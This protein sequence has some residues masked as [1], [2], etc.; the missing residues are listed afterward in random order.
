MR[1]NL[2]H[3][4]FERDSDC[5]KNN[6][7][8]DY[9]IIDKNMGIEY[10]NT[11]EEY[12]ILDVNLL[13]GEKM[14]IIYDD[15]HYYLKNG[16]KDNINI[17]SSLKKEYIINLNPEP[18]V[19]YYRIIKN[20][21]S[22]INEIRFGKSNYLKY[23]GQSEK[24]N[25]NF[26]FYI[27]L[28]NINFTSNDLHLNYKFLKIEN[29]YFPDNENVEIF[30]VDESFIIKEKEGLNNNKG[31][32][33]LTNLNE[34]SY[35]QKDMGAGY[36]LLNKNSILENLENN[37][38][39]LY[40]KFSNKPS[41]EFDFVIT[42]TDFSENYDMPQDIY[43][44]MFIKDTTHLKVYATEKGSK[45]PFLEISHDR[46]LTV[47][48]D[49]S[50]IQET[51]A[52]GKIFLSLLK[53]EINVITFKNIGKEELMPNLLFKYSFSL[54][55]HNFSYFELI[56]NSIKFNDED[57][58]KKMVSFYQIKSISDYTEYSVI[59][60]I[61][62]FDKDYDFDGILEKKKPLGHLIYK[63]QQFSEEMIE[64]NIMEELGLNFGKLY[65]NI[66]AEAKIKNKEEE[67]YEYILYKYKDIFIKAE[68]IK[69][70]ITIREKEN[71]SYF[72]YAE[73]I[74]INAT[75]DLEVGD[76]T[77]YKYIKLIL[78][79]IGEKQQLDKFE[80]YA[81]TK[82]SFLNVV[83][84]DLYK[85][86]EY[87]SIDSYNNSVLAIP[88]KNLV[89]NES[90]SQLYIQIPCKTTREF[91]FI[92]RIED[93]RKME[94][95][96]IHENTCFDI[97]LE[98][99]DEGTSNLNYRF[100]YT[101]KEKKCPLITFTTY[102]INNNYKVFT[103]G[104]EN[105]FLKKSFYN[106]YSFLFR[107]SDD[108]YEYHTF[109]IVPKI[110]TTVKICHRMIE[111]E[112]E[113]MGGEIE[114]IFRKISVGEN[115][116][117]FL[118]NNKGIIKDCF[119]LEKKDN[120]NQYMFNYISKTQN[121]RLII[122]KNKKEQENIINLYN[123]TETK[124][125]NNLSYFCIGL[126]ENDEESIETE[127]EFHG[128]INFQILG[129]DNEQ[130]INPPLVQ[131]IN[132][133][134]VKHTLQPRQMLYYR[135]NKY[136]YESE[137]LELYF[138]DL[139]GDILIKQYNYENYPNYTVKPDMPEGA[140]DIGEAFYK[141]N[142]YHKIN[143]VDKED[144]YN[145][146]KFPVYIVKCNNSSYDNCV[147]FI[148]MNNENSILEL[149]AKRKL[150]I[151]TKEEKTF[152][153]STDFYS[154]I[155]L[156]PKIDPGPWEKGSQ[157]YYFEIHLLKGKLDT[158]NISLNNSY[159]L[160]YNIDKKT[161]YYTSFAKNSF[162]VDFY[163]FPIELPI[164]NDTFFYITYRILLNENYEG[165]KIDDIY[166]MYENEMHYNLLTPLLETF[167]YY[168]PEVQFE[169]DIPKEQYIVSISGINS[170]LTLE[171]QKEIKYHQF[172]L[173][174]KVTKIT[175]K[176]END[177]KTA[178]R[179]C[180]FIFS[181][182][183]LNINT[184]SIYKKVEFDGFYQYYEMN[185]NI[186]NVCL[187]YDLTEEEIKR[188]YILVTIIKDNLE[189][190]TIYYGYETYNAPEDFE[191]LLN[192]TSIIEKNF[193]YRIN[194]TE[195]MEKNKKK[196]DQDTKKF[197]MFRLNSEKS[198]SFR[199][200]INIKN[201]PVHLY[202]DEIE[203]GNLKPNEY[204]YY[205]FDYMSDRSKGTPEDFEEIFL[206]EKGHAKMKVALIKNSEYHPYISS[207][208]YDIDF[209]DEHYKYE[210]IDSDS[211][212]KHIN[213]TNN[214]EAF[215]FGFRVCIKVYLENNNKDVDVGDY[216][217][218]KIYRHTQ[219]EPGFLAKLNTN[220]LGNIYYNNSEKYLFKTDN[221]DK[222]EGNLIVNLDCKNCSLY[223]HKTEDIYYQMNSSCIFNNWK[224]YKYQNALDYKISGEKGYYF[225]SLSDSSK[226]KYIEES[227]PELCKGS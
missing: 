8:D 17:I 158:S 92:Y 40:I 140:Q 217:S 121:M 28:N 160:L 199:I 39:Y 227:L 87:K 15:N 90:L 136:I 38:N 189:N 51:K 101:I 202:I 33:L 155:L 47:E 145:K 11:G 168:Y 21:K 212:N 210:V 127:E 31:N 188:E 10:T 119:E 4:I 103:I 16:W 141:N 79:D 80:I 200:N 34:I 182:A 214:F 100:V 206:Y 86:S 149:N 109:L 152:K 222:I 67:N 166:N 132:G 197:L 71:I 192:S 104:L 216:K 68:S 42:L 72:N 151:N 74:N 225:F 171:N 215:L 49:E 124:F 85:E 135:L 116:Y 174:K 159:D 130:N 219:K 64:A 173:L 170:Y 185:D 75:I 139:Q 113:E 157:K 89:K 128:S 110:T 115:V 211:E 56:D 178:Q 59:Y 218:F 177:E 194:L 156:K 193:I 207:D 161:Y 201:N 190:L 9:I 172:Q 186:N 83:Y 205:Y 196:L 5:I 169:N 57:K 73:N 165:K 191:N 65:I 62:I 44:F 2:V 114:Y 36:N 18:F 97:D 195:L 27:N 154:D 117:S 134:S 82:D 53:D 93:G 125:L 98:S 61:L 126:R 198:T 220:N 150:Y 37:K 29:S 22:D 122:Y 58:S 167:Y 95:I 48:Y 144:I 226:P 63:E 224:D 91:S 26:S 106:G 138:Q 223:F 137:S 133:Y 184:K 3:N 13:K 148:G 162:S 153:L 96:T 175:C 50:T 179:Q 180:E 70:D 30:C 107:Y 142:Y 102:E 213:I 176:L 88:V 52:E 183:K 187:Y 129:I 60:N 221:L 23:I 77:Q 108:Y 20:K 32:L 99:I 43:L 84:D 81:S 118:S 163:S 123:E 6:Y 131:L 69:Q 204:Y 112:E 143:I 35:Y 164:P 45:R 147:Y 105:E 14:E 209:D 12:N 54:N 181:F 19:S 66:L 120:Y 94:G 146:D 78:I 46:L 76:I 24:E 208:M 111:E 7:K 41:Q 25:S 55:E 203:F 1:I